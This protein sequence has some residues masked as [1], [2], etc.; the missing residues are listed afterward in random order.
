MTTLRMNKTMLSRKEKML[1]ASRPGKPKGTV[2]LAY[3]SVDFFI[4]ST[5]SVYSTFD[6]PPAAMVIVEKVHV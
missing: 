3:Q 4:S 1:M 5:I 2:L 6:I